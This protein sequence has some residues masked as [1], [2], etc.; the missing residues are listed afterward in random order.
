MKLSELL[1]QQYDLPSIPKVV[2]LLLTELNNAAKEF[3]QLILGNDP[4]E[5]RHRLTVDQRDYGGQRLHL[6][7]LGEPRVR[8]YVNHREHD[9]TGGFASDLRQN[10]TELCTCLA[11]RGVESDDDGYDLRQLRDRLERQ[12][13]R[14]EDCRRNVDYRRARSRACGPGSTCLPGLG[15][16]NEVAQVDRAAGNTLGHLLLH[17]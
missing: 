10:R 7:R 14:L 9:A 2:A 4:L 13:G 8:V 1:E 6:E 15:F 16:R 17:G 12:V 11:R 5:Q 3:A